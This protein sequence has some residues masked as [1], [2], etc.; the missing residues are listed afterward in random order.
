METTLETRTARE[1]G[2]EKNAGFSAD[3]YEVKT[4]HDFCKELFIST[5]L[6]Q[7]SKLFTA[8]CLQKEAPQIPPE[9]L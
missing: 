4:Q 8:C 6:K 3:G 2:L 5:V 1:H 9:G 7:F